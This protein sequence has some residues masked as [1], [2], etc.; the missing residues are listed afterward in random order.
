VAYTV[1]SYV[2]QPHLIERVVRGYKSYA[3]FPRIQAVDGFLPAA[4]FSDVCSNRRSTRS[5]GISDIN[6]AKISCILRTSLGTSAQSDVQTSETRTFYLKPYPSA[7]GLYP[8]EVYLVVFNCKDIASGVYHYDPVENNFACIDSNVDDLQKKFFVQGTPEGLYR[9][10]CAIVFTSVLSRCIAKYGQRALK[11]SLIEAGH[12]S[13]TLMLAC[14]AG[15]LSSVEWGNYLDG[16]IEELLQLDTPMETIAT[17]VLVGSKDCE[18][19]NLL[20]VS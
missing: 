19:S 6:F 14:E 1:A 16:D 20:S 18:R 13:Q 3:F 11:F 9:A 12:A 15:G 8:T 10:K 4:E 5:F 2:L 17:L 7:G